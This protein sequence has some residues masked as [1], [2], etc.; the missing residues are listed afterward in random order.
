MDIKT[1]SR[2]SVVRTK[3]QELVKQKII[4]CVK[5]AKLALFISIL[6]LLFSSFFFFF[7]I[8]IDRISRKPEMENI[9]SDYRGQSGTL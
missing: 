9:G 8:E 6:L 2:I 3:P 1:L 4:N 7:L 5:Q